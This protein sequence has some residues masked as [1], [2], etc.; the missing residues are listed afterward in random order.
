MIWT[1][2]IRKQEPLGH[3]VYLHSDALMGIYSGYL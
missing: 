2:A 3:A 1:G